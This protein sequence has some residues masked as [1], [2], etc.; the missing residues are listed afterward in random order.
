ML[1]FV[2]VFISVTIPV[3]GQSKA[4]VCCPFA[5]WDCGFESSR[6]HGCLSRMSVLCC[7]VEVSALG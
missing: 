4:W 3:P 6:G 7:Q 2:M 5:C 1:E